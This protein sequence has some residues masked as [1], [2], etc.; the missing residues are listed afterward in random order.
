MHVRLPLEAVGGWD[1]SGHSQPWRGPSWNVAISFLW[2]S[3]PG[4]MLL[5]QAGMLSRPRPCR[6]KPGSLLG[7]CY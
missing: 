7:G 6:W 1:S 4:Q 3:F 2:R 5:H